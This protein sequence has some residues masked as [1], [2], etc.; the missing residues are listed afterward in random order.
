VDGVPFHC[1]PYAAIHA[2]LRVADLSGRRHN[3]DAMPERV[4]LIGER[5]G[6]RV[7]LVADWR[8]STASF[9]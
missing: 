8:L 5:V 9:A 3:A 2:A 4:E 6:F 1:R 7:E